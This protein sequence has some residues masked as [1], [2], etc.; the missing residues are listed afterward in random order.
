MINIL[1]IKIISTDFFLKLFLPFLKEVMPPYFLFFIPQ[2]SEH[3]FK[4]RGDSFRDIYLPVESSHELGKVSD[5]DFLSDSGAKKSPDTGHACHLSQHLGT[6]RQGAQSGGN[7]TRYTDLYKPITTSF[8]HNMIQCTKRHFL[9]LEYYIIN[10]VWCNGE[11]N[12]KS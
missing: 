12:W 5:F 9:I 2:N 4:I 1:F 7:T 6:R 3:V 11:Q 10:V 8:S